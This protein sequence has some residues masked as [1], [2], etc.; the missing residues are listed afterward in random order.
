MK[1][2]EMVPPGIA[3]TQHG[4][5]QGCP[6]LDLPG[7]DPLSEDG[8]NIN[9]VICDDRRDPVTGSIPIKSYHCRLVKQL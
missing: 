7:F 1:I 3:A 5:W 4:W 8:A 9:L 6:E 2:T